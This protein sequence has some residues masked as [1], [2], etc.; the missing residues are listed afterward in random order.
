MCATDGFS[1][2]NTRLNKLSLFEWNNILLKLKLEKR[3]VH[4]KNQGYITKTFIF[5]IKYSKTIKKFSKEILN[6]FVKS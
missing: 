5:C 4:V 6:V 3:I 2:V 1:Q